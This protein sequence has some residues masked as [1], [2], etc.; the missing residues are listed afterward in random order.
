MATA[1]V[2]IESSEALDRFCRELTACEW[3][4]LDTEF[5]REQTYYPRLCLVQIAVPGSVALIDPLAIA[6]LSPLRKMLCDRSRLKVLHAAS[7]DLEIF[8]HL[9]GE[10][11]VPIFDTQVAA[12]LLGQGDQT[13]YGKLVE[14]M[15]GITLPKGH[16]RTDWSRRPLDPAQSEY[17]AADVIHLC[18]LYLRIRA[19]LERNGRLDW[20][21]ADFTE[22]GDPA[23]YRPDPANAWRRLRGARSLPERERRVI[24]ALATWREETAMKSDR[25]RRWIL[26][27]DALIDIAR[28]RPQD[29]GALT[30]IRNLNDSLIRR[31]GDRL[32]EIVQAAAE[33]PLPKG[34]EAS[35]RRL[36]RDEEALVDAAQ[37]LLKLCAAEAGVSPSLLASRRDIEAL[38]RGEDDGAL[39]TGWRARLAGNTLREFIAGKSCLRVDEAGLRLKTP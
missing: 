32:I 25:P 4:A 31:Y 38:V 24:A 18:D 17:A 13:G 21:A 1:P 6:D 36:G 39:S 7:Q 14:T 37:A 3:L 8:F 15:L 12:A 34:F 2:F 5:I 28:L 29:R 33:L 26:P 23:R 35:P 27:D 22:L 19:D 9:W 16:A 20:L 10:V 30:R 11:P